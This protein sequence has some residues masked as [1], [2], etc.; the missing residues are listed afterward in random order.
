MAK[1]SFYLLAFIMFLSMTGY[2]IV[3]PALPYL[4]AHLGLNSFQMGSLITGWAF[5]QFVTVPFWGRLIDRIGRKPILV[6]G[7]FGFGIAFLLMIFAQSYAQLLLIRIIGAMVSTGTMPAVYAMI[8]DVYDKKQRGPVIAKMAAA[9]T[10]GFLCGPVVGSALS[11][12]GINM[13]FIVA[14]LLS[15]ITIPFAIIFLKESKRK[16]ARKDNP[17][18]VKSIGILIQPGC[19]EL[20]LMTFG[21]AVAASGFFSMLGYFMIERFSTNASQTGLAFSTE[22]LA[23]VILQV[24]VMST[25]YR[26]LGELRIAKL[27]SLI[28]AGGYACIAFSQSVWMIFI[29]CALIGIGNALVQPTLVSLLSKQDTVGQG[30]VMSLQQAMDSLGRSIGPLLA[31]W[32]FFY[33]DSAPFWG[34]TALVLITL[35]VFV[36]RE[37]KRTDHPHV[38]EYAAR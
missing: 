38:N 28:N 20:F 27:G 9:N 18:F 2:G 3:F 5:S 35:A 11:P 37:K 14:S 31:G 30:M 15:F 19:W 12:F 34:A 4:A 17:S 13:P 21:I 22:S 26:K 29:G 8:S 23:T 1:R 25:I 24:F 6:F 16:A 32:L 10:L 33:Q 36:F 7:L